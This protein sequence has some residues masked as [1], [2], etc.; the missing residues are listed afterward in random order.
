MRADGALVGGGD[1]TDDG[2]AQARGRYF[3]LDPAAAGLV[4]FA[5][6][7]A[8]LLPPGHDAEL[9]EQA[10][11]SSYVIFAAGILLLTAFVSYRAP[12]VLVNRDVRR[13]PVTGLARR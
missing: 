13:D 5:V 4:I 9:W 7:P 2:Q 3:H 1:G 6:S 8:W 10:A 12:P 11:A